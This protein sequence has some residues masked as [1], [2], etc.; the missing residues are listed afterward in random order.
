MKAGDRYEKDSDR[1]VQEASV[2]SSTKFWN[3]AAH[4]AQQALLWFLEQWSRSAGK[5]QGR[6]DGLARPNYATIHR[7]TLMTRLEP[8]RRGRDGLDEGRP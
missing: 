7:M 4:G 2:W 5:E 1:R 8:C 3:L 6:R